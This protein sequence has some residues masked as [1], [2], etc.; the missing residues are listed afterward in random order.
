MNIDHETRSRGCH[1][2]TGESAIGWSNTV[3]VD[4]EGSAVAD[5]DRLGFCMEHG[6]LAPTTAATLFPEP[7]G[8]P[9]LAADL[10]DGRWRVEPRGMGVG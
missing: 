9:F 6:C 4:L 10:G 8:G 5:V 7:G 3:E 2:R 1:Q